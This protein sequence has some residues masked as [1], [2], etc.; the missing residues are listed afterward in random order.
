M[1]TFDNLAAARE[2]I[3]TYRFGPLLDEGETVIETVQLLSA[4]VSPV[5]QVMHIGEYL[6]ARRADIADSGKDLAGGLIAFATVNAWHGLLND[7][8]GNK[9]VQA[10]RRDLGETPP[11]GLEWPDEVDDPAP[12]AMFAE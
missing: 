12:L 7:D 9:I 5:A 2:A 8:R 6:Y 1:Q 3:M 4:A 10:L 11:I